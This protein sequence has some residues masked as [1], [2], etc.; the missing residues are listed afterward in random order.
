MKDNNMATDNDMEVHK[1]SWTPV[2]IAVGVIFL[3]WFAGS[4]AFMMYAFNAENPLA[5]AAI[6]QYFLVFGALAI[7]ANIKRVKSGKKFDIPVLLIPL[8]GIVLIGVSLVQ[9]FGMPL[10]VQGLMEKYDFEEADIIVYS[11]FGLFIV[12]GVGLIMSVVLDLKKKARCSDV[13]SVTCVH[14]DEKFM[15]N[16]GRHTRVYCPTWEAFYAGR[17]RTY[18]NDE[19][20]V[21]KKYAVGTIS[22]IHVNPENPDEYYDSANTYKNKIVAVLGFCFVIVPVWGLVMMHICG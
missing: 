3:F 4:L 11:V 14:V 18:V 19:Q 17:K 15:S 1:N 10:F 5:F 7:S 2:Q 8:V 22:E 13:I 16:N 12:I 9:V 21:G 20:Y 6:G